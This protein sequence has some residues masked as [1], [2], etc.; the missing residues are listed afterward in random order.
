MKT[1]I[2]NLAALV[3][4]LVVVASG[5]AAKGGPTPDP[6]LGG[7]GVKASGGAVRYVALPGGPHATTV[8]A[9]RVRDG[10]VLQ[11]GVVPG[12]LGIPQVAWDG[13]SDGLSADGRRLVLASI[14]SQPIPART[15]FVVLRSGTLRTLRTIRLPGLWAFDAISPDGATIYALQYGAAADP[16]HYSV[17]AIDTISGRIF[18]GAIVDRREPDEEMRGSPVTRSWSADREWAFTL[19]SKPNGTAFVHGLDTTKR[20]AVCLDLP[21]RGIGKTIGQVRLRVSSDGRTLMLHQSGIGRLASVDL[22]SLVVRSF[23]P[24]VAPGVPAS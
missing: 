7:D 21:W 18:P 5:A 19:Y 23:R 10:R 1:M 20:N 16:S 6:L 2:C 9:V 3:I 12:V 13:T 24:P 11:F 15:T 22:S 8:A 17:R 4:A 14:S